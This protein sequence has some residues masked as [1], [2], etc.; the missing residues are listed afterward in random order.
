MVR[1]L[2]RG[3]DFVTRQ[4]TGQNGIKTLDTLGGLAIGYGF[5]LERMQS[6]K[7]AICSNESDVLST[8]HTAVAFGINGTFDITISPPVFAEPD[9]GQQ[10][11]VM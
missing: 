7:S 8:S 11:C 9:P 1:I 5:D 2:L 4:L 6:T 3:L 10:S